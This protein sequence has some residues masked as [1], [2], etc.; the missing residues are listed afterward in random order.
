[1]TDLQKIYQQIDS[2]KAGH[3]RNV[4]AASKREQSGGC[5]DSAEREQTRPKVNPSVGLYLRRLFE[6]GSWTSQAAEPSSVMVIYTQS[7]IQ[8]E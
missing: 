4:K 2:E 7:L 3:Y 6:E 8:V 1:M 5:F